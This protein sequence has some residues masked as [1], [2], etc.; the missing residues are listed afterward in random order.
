MKEEELTKKAKQLKAEYMR[1]Y[2][3]RPEVKARQIE[4]NKRYWNKKAKEHQEK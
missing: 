2:R 3:K 4:Y 1:E